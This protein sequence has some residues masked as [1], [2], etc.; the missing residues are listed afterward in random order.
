MHKGIEYEVV[1]NTADLECFVPE[2]SALWSADPFATPFQSPEWLLPWWHQFGQQDLCAIVILQDGSAVGFLPFYVYRDLITEE[3]QLLLNG[4]GTTD[5]LDGVFSR[6]CSL[7]HV[8]EALRIACDSKNWDRMIVFQLRRESLLLQA[9]C[10]CEAS[11]L[12]DTESC[13]RIR[14]VGIAGLP[15]HIRRNVRYYRNCAARNGELEMVEADEHNWLQHFEELRRLHCECWNARDQAGVLT[16]QRVLAWHREAIPKL[17]RAELLK[18]Y[19]L[20]LNGE[21]IA[22]A[23]TLLDPPQRRGRT[24]YLYL[25]GYSARH[26]ELSPGTLLLAQIVAQAAAQDVQTIDLL[27]GDEAYKHLWHSEKV[28]TYGCARSC[29]RA[30]AAVD[31]AFWENYDFTLA[32]P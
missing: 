11:G 8:S 19:S 3:R 20:R 21:A 4:A 2:W 9:L 16:D 27:R 31:R 5:Y 25:M 13:S 26:A 29:N 18:L 23:Y 12:F 28:P 10:R 32:A 30:G 1:R 24:Q 14:P 17:L 22:A 15:K 6:H 7:E